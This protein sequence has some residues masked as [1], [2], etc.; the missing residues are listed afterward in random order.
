L[1]LNAS[2]ATLLHAVQLLV[3]AAVILLPV[4]SVALVPVAILVAAEHITISIC[5]HVVWLS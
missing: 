5:D 1:A 4:V 3:V 2:V